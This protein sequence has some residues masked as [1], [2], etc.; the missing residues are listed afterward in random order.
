MVLKGS[1]ELPSLQQAVLA[2]ELV[3]AL[4]LML[5]EVTNAHLAGQ[6]TRMLFFSVKGLGCLVVDLEKPLDAQP[7]R[8]GSAGS[9]DQ[10]SGYEG[11]VRCR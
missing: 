9:A 8:T 6:F 7:G 11:A 10:R 4:E 1:V 2:A 3:L 5:T